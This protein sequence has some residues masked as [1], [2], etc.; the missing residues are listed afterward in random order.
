YVGWQP[1]RPGE[2]WHRPGW[3]ER[4][5]N[6]AGWRHPIYHATNNGV[7]VLP[8]GAFNGSAAVRPEAP[9]R[10]HGRLLQGFDRPH[11]GAAP[12]S[13]GVAGVQP[14][15]FAGNPVRPVDGGKIFA[16]QP[17]SGII[18]RSVLTRHM[19]TS[20]ATA[21]DDGATV[22]RE[23]RLVQPAAPGSEGPVRGSG[24]VWAGDSNANSSSQGDQSRG[25]RRHNPSLEDGQDSPGS[26]SYT[27]GSRAEERRRL[28]EDTNS[29]GDE[30]PRHKNKATDQGQFNSDQRNN[31]RYESPRH[32]SPRHESPRYEAPANRPAPRPE[33]EGP[34]YS[35]GSGGSGSN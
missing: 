35:G 6:Q 14:G 18:N 26:G 4:H 21:V 12:I 2:V 33:R 15:R 13:A 23:R 3:Y 20:P 1:L 17:P 27:P 29:S 9:N 28:R 22:R 7:S 5:P 30:S 34:K 24:T 32:E 25:I 11:P 31:Q 16:I 8:I 10:E 19:P